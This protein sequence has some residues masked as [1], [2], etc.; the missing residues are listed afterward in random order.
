[1]IDTLFQQY[2]G[3]FDEVYEVVRMFVVATQDSDYRIEV[4][5]CWPLGG[6]KPRIYKQ[7]TVALPG[8]SEMII[9]R[10]YEMGYKATSDPDVAVKMALSVI[11]H[12]RGR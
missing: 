11:K 9:W 7:E 3:D 8:R 1:M 10:E 12:Q 5:R 4:L 2:Q 6:Y